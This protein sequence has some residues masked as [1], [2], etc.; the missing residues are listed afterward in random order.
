MRVL[1]G[2]SVLAVFG[3]VSP[4]ICQ[5]MGIKTKVY[6]AEISFDALMQLVGREPMKVQE[7]SRFP[8]V[9]RDLALVIDKD[10]SFEAIEQIARQTEKKKLKQ[11]GL[12]DL[13]ENEQHLGKGKKSYAV[14]FI[15]ENL[16]KTM[17]DQEID[18]IMTR[19][20]QAFETGV[21]ALIRK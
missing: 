21:G 12:F 19:M 3:E 14:S 1:K 7:I 20:I 15:F 6:Y 9:R 8:S 18:Q 11:V 10:V 4:A 16:E 5:K 2:K 17:N 13:Y